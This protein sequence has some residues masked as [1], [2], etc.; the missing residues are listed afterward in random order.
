MALKSNFLHLDN[1][2]FDFGEVEKAMFQGFARHWEQIF[3]LLTSPKCYLGEFGI[4]I[5][6]GLT[7][8]FELFFG[9]LNISKCELVEVEKSMLQV[10]PKALRTHYQTLDYLKIRNV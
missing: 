9:L 7:Y 4:T 1:P 3:F 5:F 10:F 8:H 2:K 6:Q